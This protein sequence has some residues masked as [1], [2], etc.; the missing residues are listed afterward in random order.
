MPVAASSSL[1]VVSTPKGAP[2]GICN[3]IDAM[4]AGSVPRLCWELSRWLKI[5]EGTADG[6]DGI[7]AVRS[8]LRRSKRKRHVRIAVTLPQMDQW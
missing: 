6:E 5:S 4:K 2:A 1:P 7:V 8:A 3:P